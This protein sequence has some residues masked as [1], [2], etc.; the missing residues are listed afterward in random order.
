[1]S[2]DRFVDPEGVVEMAVRTEAGEAA[3]G[4]KLHRDVSTIG[5]LFVCLGSVI[6]SGWLFGALYAAQIA[7]PASII[8]WVL[9][10]LVMLVLALVHAELGS[11]YPVAGGSAR[12][13][14][15]AFG[16]VAGFTTGWIVWVGAVTVA[17]IEVLAALQYLTHYFPWLTSTTGGVTVLTS[18][19]IVISVV[20]M[21]VFT[22]IN[23]L[24]VASLAKSNNVIMIWKIAI[25][26]L[27]I[28]VIMILSFHTTNFFHPTHGGF[29]PFG[30]QG[31][32]SAIATGG[33]I[34]SYQGFEQAI[35]FGGETRN[36]A[37]NIPFAVIGSMAIGAVLYILLEV[38][39]LGAL[40]PENLKKGWD[41]ITFPGLAGP[42]AGLAT[43]VGATWLAVL[44]YIDAFVS[45][46]GTGLIYLSSSARLT[47][48]MGRNHYIPRPFGYLS[49]RGVPLVSIIFAFLIGCIM[50]LPFPGWQEL[51]GFIVSA[52][53]LGYA[54]VPLAFGAMRRQE[55]DHPRPFKLPAGEILAP[56]AFIVANLVIYWTGW[57]ILWKLFAAIVLGFVLLAIGHVV[58][59]S[60]LTPSFDWRGGSW[61]LPYLVGMGVISYIGASDFGG[62]G[63]ISFGWD[64]P[65]VAVF[66]LAIYFY[67]ISVRLTP[68]EVRRHVADARDEAEEEQELAV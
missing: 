35:Q 13:P 46:S 34:F 11:M 54:A 4:R 1:V 21:A 20:L 32:L 66:S 18:I 50:F 2:H 42:F 6:G 65:V 27:A 15:F 64:I 63:I 12:Y 8:S 23:L 9:G 25:P 17:P 56:I 19:G 16:S 5:L 22:V 49:E 53:V 28:I 44:L 57:E 47:Y 58:N 10:A 14:H 24:G 60:E 68:E 43:A 39:F 40:E 67:A 51:V 29:A 62:I 26:F 41:E 55:P 31:V 3:A 7:G 45:P 37:R 52:A 33:I 30:I 36:P 61:Y 59:P 38:A 48:A